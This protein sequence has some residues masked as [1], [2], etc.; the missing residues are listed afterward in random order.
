MFSERFK[1][2]FRGYELYYRLFRF[3]K[4]KLEVNLQL[5][6]HYFGLGFKYEAE[7][8]NEYSLECM[9]FWLHLTLYLWI[10]K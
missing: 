8:S 6:L 7:G 1:R 3:S 4:Y 5:F 2:W 9:L 10:K